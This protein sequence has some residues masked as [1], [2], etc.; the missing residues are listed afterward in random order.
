LR[1]DEGVGFVELPASHDLRKSFEVLGAGVV[2]R[3]DGAGVPGVGGNVVER[4]A[5]AGF[6]KIAEQRLGA[7]M[8]LIGGEASPVSGLSVVDRN[9]NAFEIAVSEVVLGFSQALIRGSAVPFEGFTEVDVNGVAEIVEIAEIELSRRIPVERGSAIPLQG[10]RQ[11]FVNA[12][13]AFIE[14][15]DIVFRGSVA[16]KRRDTVVFEGLGVVARETLAVLVEIANEKFGVGHLLRGKRLKPGE[17][18]VV[19][20]GGRIGRDKE[21][22]ELVPRRRIAS[23]GVRFKFG[24]GDGRAGVLLRNRSSEAE[25]SEQERSRKREEKEGIGTTKR[26]EHVISSQ[27]V[28][29]R[30]MRA[31]GRARTGSTPPATVPWD[32]A[33][34]TGGKWTHSYQRHAGRTASL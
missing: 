26:R 18:Q 2:A 16:V 11:I 25:R 30:F 28:L 29:T 4:K 33:E 24:D 19:T 6:I 20:R 9:A 23:I 21:C 3:G 27:G 31:G 1:R 10:K 34:Q 15:T 12:K 8:A 5:L 22:S 7:R 17:G 14:R 13:A 32:R